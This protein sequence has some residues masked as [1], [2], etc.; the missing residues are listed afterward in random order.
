M[1]YSNQERDHNSKISWF[2]SWD[3]ED[4]LLFCKA[5]NPAADPQHDFF[6]VLTGVNIVRVIKSRRIRW[7]WFVVFMGK[8]RFIQGFSGET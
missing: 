6:S 3:G 8:E 5:T 4:I 1:L 2:D 7:K